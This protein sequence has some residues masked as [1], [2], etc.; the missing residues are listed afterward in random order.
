MTSF[1]LPITL[2]CQ[3][4]EHHEGG[5]RVDAQVRLD[6]HGCRELAYCRACARGFVEPLTKTIDAGGV[7]QCGSCG[8]VYIAVADFVTEGAL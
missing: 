4:R 1:P 5:E 8:H 6:I 2:H 3:C 7:L